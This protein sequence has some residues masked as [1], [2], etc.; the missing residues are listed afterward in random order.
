MIELIQ[1]C[2]SDSLFRRLI[3]LSLLPNLFVWGFSEV[4]INSQSNYIWV[5]L[6]EPYWN[7]EVLLF[8]FM[9]AS[10]VFYF[11]GWHSL[12]IKTELKRQREVAFEA[13]NTRN[14]QEAN[15]KLAEIEEIK[16]KQKEFEILAQKK[17]ALPPPRP[18]PKP[19]T[20]EDLKAKALKQ[21]VDGF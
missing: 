15:R 5:H 8:K 19:L 13:E 4:G 3:F 7:I 14:V 2:F 17:K 18:R 21:I 9:T 1:A 11:I 10:S 12:S 20:T 16:R 6:L